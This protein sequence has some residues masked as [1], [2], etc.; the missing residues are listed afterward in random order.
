M[1]KQ[2]KKPSLKQTEQ[3]EL[4]VF[5]TCPLKLTSILLKVLQNQEEMRLNIGKK[6]KNSKSRL[7]IH[8]RKSVLRLAHFRK[9]FET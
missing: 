5:Q 8:K 9:I 7:K 2:E 3:L 1:L 6:I 4:K